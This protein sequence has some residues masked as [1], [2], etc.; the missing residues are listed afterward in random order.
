MHPQVYMWSVNPTGQTYFWNCCLR[1]DDRPMRQCPI[2][3]DVYIW[4][5]LYNIHCISLVLSLKMSNFSPTNKHQHWEV[6]RKKGEWLSDQILSFS[7][8]AFGIWLLF[9]LKYLL[10]LLFLFFFS[11]ILYFICNIFTINNKF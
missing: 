10:H 5:V 8:P 9:I 1:P 11:I 3:F 6:W 2:Q 7:N 4:L